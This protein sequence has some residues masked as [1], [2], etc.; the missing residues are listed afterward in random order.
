MRGSRC[1]TGVQVGREVPVTGN[2]KQVSRCIWKQ[3]ESPGTSGGWV[4][5]GRRPVK[6]GWDRNHDR[7]SI[8]WHLLYQSHAPAAYKYFQGHH[9]T[10]ACLFLRHDSASLQEICDLNLS[11]NSVNLSRAFPSVRTHTHETGRHAHTATRGHTG[12]I[13]AQ[14]R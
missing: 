5:Y 6:Q 10:S 13:C 12:T 8:C 2:G 7:L 4:E 3:E 1:G 11:I 14:G 9:E